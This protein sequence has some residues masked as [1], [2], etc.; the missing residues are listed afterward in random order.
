[1]V[2]PPLLLPLPPKPVAPPLPP[3]KRLAAPAEP[4]LIVSAAMLPFF[5]C[6]PRMT[7]V[8]PG[9][10]PVTFDETVFVTLDAGEVVTLT[11][12]PLESVT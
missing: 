7:T 5:C 1:M 4:T 11:V 12:F 6:V 2:V 9:R 3:P 10:M 8:S